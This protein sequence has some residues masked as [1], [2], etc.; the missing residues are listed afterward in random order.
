MKKVKVTK[1]PGPQGELIVLPSRLRMFLIY[2]VM[3]SLAIGIGLLLRLAV[4][5]E[6]FT[7]EW[8]SS[9]WISWL[10]VVIGGAALM[11]LIER[12]RWKLRVV[13]RDKLEGPTGAFGERLVIPFNEID[14]PRTQRSLSSKLKI[15]NAI[16]GRGRQRI[17]VSQAFFDPA[18]LSELLR[19]IGYKG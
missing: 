12:S 14:W 4:D 19:A 9:G 18:A 8:L 7:A 2:M 10:G 17:I 3:F 1:R 13:E 5:R 15:G 6:S 11:A 16:Y